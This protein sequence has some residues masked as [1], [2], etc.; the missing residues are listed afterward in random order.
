MVGSELSPVMA[1]RYIHVSANQLSVS[2]PQGPDRPRLRAPALRAGKQ[3]LSDLGAQKR[4]GV[5]LTVG[6]GSLVTGGGRQSP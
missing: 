6:E 1:G 4:M 2:S 5:C 3:G